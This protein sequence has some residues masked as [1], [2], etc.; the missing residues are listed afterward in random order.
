MDQLY[1]HGRSRAGLRHGRQ[2]SSPGVYWTFVFAWVVDD[3][4]EDLDRFPSA[5]PGFHFKP[6]TR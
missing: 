2:G 4:E 3:R 1:A 6:P 5:Q